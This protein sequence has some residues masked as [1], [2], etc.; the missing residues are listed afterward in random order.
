LPFSLSEETTHI[1]FRLFATAN[2]QIEIHKVTVVK[3]D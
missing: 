3:K 1:E 2:T